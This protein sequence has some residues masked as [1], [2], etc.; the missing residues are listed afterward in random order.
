MV[1]STHFKYQ[2]MGF[3]S[4]QKGGQSLLWD[5]GIARSQTT[6]GHCTVFFFF[7]FFGV[8]RGGGGEGRRS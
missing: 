6:P 8:S 7:V 5:S 2:I 1:A 4:N 3:I